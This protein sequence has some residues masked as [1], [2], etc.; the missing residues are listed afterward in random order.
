MIQNSP[1]LKDYAFAFNDNGSVVTFGVQAK[2]LFDAFVRLL[3]SKQAL[4]RFALMADGHDGDD[5]GDVV[6]YR[7][8]GTLHVHVFNGE[9]ADAAAKKLMAE[10]G[11]RR[12]LVASFNGR[13]SRYYGC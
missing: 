2:T 11:K 7:E 13:I 4:P 8:G 3:H 9:G 5:V 10:R 1:A 6:V 12:E